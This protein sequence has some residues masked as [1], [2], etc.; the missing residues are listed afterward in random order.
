MC[1]DLIIDKQTYVS[2]K[3]HYHKTTNTH[4]GANTSLVLFI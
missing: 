4:I 2:W 3:P 1:L